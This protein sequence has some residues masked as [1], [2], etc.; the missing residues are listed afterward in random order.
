VLVV[1]AALA[2]AGCGG[3]SKNVSAFT[4]DELTALPQQDW[5]TNDGTVFNQRYA[6]EQQ[7]WMVRAQRAL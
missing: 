3:S 6:L 5:I 7:L 4:A 2:L 1:A